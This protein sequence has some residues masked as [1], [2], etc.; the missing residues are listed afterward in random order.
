M[1]NAQKVVIEI[2]YK[3]NLRFYQTMDEIGM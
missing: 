1:P 2:R 3:A